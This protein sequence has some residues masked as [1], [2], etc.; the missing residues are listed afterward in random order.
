MGQIVHYCHV[1]TFVYPDHKGR[2][3]AVS[4][5]FAV[6]FTR[7]HLGCTYLQGLVTCRR[8]LRI[9]N[10]V[11]KEAKVETTL[12]KEKQERRHETHLVGS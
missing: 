4:P 7:G 9:L 10:K 3:V 2:T 1:G 8:C 11:S 12:R 5:G 6:C